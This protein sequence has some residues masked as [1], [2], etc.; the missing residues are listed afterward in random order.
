[1]YVHTYVRTYSTTSPNNGH[2]GSPTHCQHVTPTI[3]SWEPHSSPSVITSIIGN[4]TL[5][6]QPHPLSVTT[7]TH[8]HCGVRS[9]GA[10]ASAFSS[11]GTQRPRS[12]QDCRHVSSPQVAGSG[13]AQ[14]LSGFRTCMPATRRCR[15]DLAPVEGGV[16]GN[17]NRHG[18]RCNM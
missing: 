7:P 3:R 15:L 8:S 17:S 14:P 1:M 6:W 10:A 2:T 9:T 18:H 4:L 11:Q 12:P 5:H 16:K 13:L